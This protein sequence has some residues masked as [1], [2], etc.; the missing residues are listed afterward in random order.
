MKRSTP[1]GLDEDDLKTLH[2]VI[3]AWRTRKGQMLNELFEPSHRPVFVGG[4]KN[5]G[6]R[7]NEALLKDA[8][9]KAKTPGERNKTG[10]MVSP[11]IEYL[12]WSYLGFDPKYVEFPNEEVKP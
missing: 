5:T 8:S 3:M 10:G 7:I 6:I 9:E 12:L 4:K 11:L 1:P 2:E